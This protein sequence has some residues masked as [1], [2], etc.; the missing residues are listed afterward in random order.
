VAHRKVEVEACGI[1]YLAFS[2]HKAYAPFGSGV[3]VAKKGLLNFRPDELELIRLSG[4]ENAG[5]IAAL[6]KSLVLLQR[7]GFAVIQADEQALT[8]RTLRGLQQIPGITVYGISDPDAPQFAHKG[9]VIVFRVE[10]IMAN[11]VAKELAER[12][13]I[14]VRSGCHCAHLLI[15]RLLNIPP[16]LE[17]FQGVIL[18]LFKQVSLPGLTRVSLGI[19]NSTEEIDTLIQVLRNIAAQPQSGSD[20]NVQRRINEFAEAAIQRVYACSCDSRP[21]TA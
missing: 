21:S 15:K 3:L 16:A 13:G 18:T 7:I 8:A 9:G 17:Q 12:G 14:G 5:G 19:E 6:G 1:D 20:G 4:E 11:R 2:A 10:G